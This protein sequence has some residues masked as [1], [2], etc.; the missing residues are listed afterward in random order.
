MLPQAAP[1]TR[2]RL[3]RRPLRLSPLESS[4][5]RL[6]ARRSVCPGSELCF[7]KGSRPEVL[8]TRPGSAAA[9]CAAP[10]AWGDSGGGGGSAS[11]GSCYPF[12]P[13]TPESF[14]KSFN[15]LKSLHTFTCSCPELLRGA[16]V[17]FIWLRPASH[18]REVWPVPASCP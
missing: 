4:P 7:S 11:P 1:S 17:G 13:R 14:N 5:Q 9:A 8:W 12:L 6:A 16:W 18:L 3:P 10:R 2:A 15:S